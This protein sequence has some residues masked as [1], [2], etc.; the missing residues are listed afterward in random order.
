VSAGGKIFNS[1]SAAAKDITETNINGLRFWRAQ[2]PSESRWVLVA[3]LPTENP[4]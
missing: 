3:G 2:L 1:L 4:A